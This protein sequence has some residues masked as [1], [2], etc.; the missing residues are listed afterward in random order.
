[1]VQLSHPYMTMGKAIALTIRTFIG[2]V[3]SLLFHMLS[4]LVITFFPSSKNLLI[5]R[6]QPPSAV[7][8]EHKK[9]H[10]TYIYIYVHMCIYIYIYIH[11]CI[12]IHIYIETHTHTYLGWGKGFP[13][14]PASKE[15]ACNVGDLGSVPGLGRS[16]GEGMGIHS[17]ILAWRIPWTIHGVAGWDTTEL[18]SLH[19]S[20]GWEKRNCSFRLWILNHCN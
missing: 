20:S 5:S 15:S 10:I 14:G 16:P 13:G 6:Q 8:F 3:M 7:I 9:I 1:M 17:S 4:R 11:I 2:K 19:F 18:L 12:C